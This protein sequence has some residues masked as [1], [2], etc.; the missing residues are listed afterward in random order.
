MIEDVD[1]RS[2][3]KGDRLFDV[4]VSAKC[5]NAWVLIEL[6]GLLIVL[7]IVPVRLLR[8]HFELLGVTIELSSL[9]IE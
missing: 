9:L 7:S 8:L 3:F 4:R 2:H 5:L 1:A 6:L